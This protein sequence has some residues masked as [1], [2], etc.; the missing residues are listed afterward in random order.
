MSDRLEA[1]KK[2]FGI[3]VHNIQWL[4][5]EVERLRE[6]YKIYGD[7]ISQI[8]EERDSLTKERDD[9]QREFSFHK[10]ITKDHNN[11][12]Y[13]RIESLTKERDRFKRIAENLLSDY[14]WIQYNEYSNEPIKLEDF[15]EPIDREADSL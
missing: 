11:E 2:T 7:T 14:N 6:E 5:D 8:M 4:I 1:I 15:E 10:G 3:Q 9:L 12:L 13:E